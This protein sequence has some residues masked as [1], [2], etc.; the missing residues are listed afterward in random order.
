MLAKPHR[1]LAFTVVFLVLA[2]FMESKA[3]RISTSFLPN[4]QTKLQQ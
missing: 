1:Q 2:G 4:R 3:P